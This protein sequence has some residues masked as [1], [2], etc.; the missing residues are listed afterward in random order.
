MWG[1]KIARTSI[2][3]LALIEH[4]YKFLAVDVGS[5]GT[6]GDAGIFAKSHIGNNLLKAIKFPPTG[7]LPRTETVLPYVILEDEAFKLTTTLMRQYPHNQEKQ[8]QTRLSA[9]T[10]SVLLGHAKM[11]SV[12]CAS[13][14]GT[15]LHL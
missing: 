6:E 10:D 8:I 9:T 1:Y 11:P 12:F 5:Y 15:F 4:N 13:N 2:V 7:P 14:L 3:M